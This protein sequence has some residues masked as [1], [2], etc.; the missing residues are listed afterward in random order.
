LTFDGVIDFQIG[1]SKRKELLG[2]E[3]RNCKYDLLENKPNVQETNQIP[4]PGFRRYMI[5]FIETK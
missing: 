1:L 2:D 5:D 3:V 4:W